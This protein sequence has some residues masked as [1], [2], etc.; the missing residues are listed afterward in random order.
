MS[1]ELRAKAEAM[2][3][4]ADPVNTG[5]RIVG[6]VEWRDGTVIDVVRELAK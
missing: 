3:G 5:D 2:S 4:I 1:V 6:V